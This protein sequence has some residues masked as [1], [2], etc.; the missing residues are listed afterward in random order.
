MTTALL[1]S[2]ILI[3]C[4]GATNGDDLRSEYTNYAALDEDT[5][6]FF[7]WSINATDSS[8]QFAVQAKTTGWV[9]FGISTGQG[10]MQG[11]DIVIGWVKDGET[12]Y[13]VSVA[14]FKTY[15]PVS[16]PFAPVAISK[17]R[18]LNPPVCPR[19]ANYLYWLLLWSSR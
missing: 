9:G 16:M 5:N 6:V 19:D 10:K 8:I 7:Y 13:A 2:S 18:A 1:L 3:C 14:Q 11:A 12:F 4:L 15:S 17:L